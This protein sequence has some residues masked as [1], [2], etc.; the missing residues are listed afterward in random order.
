MIGSGMPD[1]VHTVR[2]EVSPVQPDR[3]PASSQ[4]KQ[5]YDPKKYDG[6]V[7]RFGTVMLIGDIVP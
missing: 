2:V 6:T 4:E 7:L 5:P 1:T 3:A